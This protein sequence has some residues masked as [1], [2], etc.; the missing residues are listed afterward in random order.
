MLGPYILGHND[1][2]V[3]FDFSTWQPKL[4]QLNSSF[5]FSDPSLL[6]LLSLR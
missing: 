1:F 2:L 6:V 3:K 4:I 5:Q